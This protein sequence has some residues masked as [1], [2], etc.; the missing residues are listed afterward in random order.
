MFV[1]TVWKFYSHDD[2]STD[3]NNKQF[4]GYKY[5]ISNVDTPSSATKVVMV[6]MTIFCKGSRGSRVASEICL[7]KKFD[8]NGQHTTL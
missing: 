3:R 4:P 6:H 2:R 5:L 1:L 7:S 8:H